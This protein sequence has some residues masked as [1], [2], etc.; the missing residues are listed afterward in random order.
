LNLPVASEGPNLANLT[1]DLTLC[2]INN[3]TEARLFT[4]QTGKQTLTAG[5][6]RDLARG[7]LPGFHVLFRLDL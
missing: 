1:H 3:P 2:I 5:Q 6:I 4:V 7:K